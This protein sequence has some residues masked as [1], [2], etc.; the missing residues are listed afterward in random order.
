MIIQAHI[1]L[2]SCRTNDRRYFVRKG[3]LEH[4]IAKGAVRHY[5]VTGSSWAAIRRTLKIFDCY[6]YTG[7]GPTTVESWSK[8]IGSTYGRLVPVFSFPCLVCQKLQ[9]FQ[10]NRS[11]TLMNS[12]RPAP[13]DKGITV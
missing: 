6:G 3:D 8:D 9:H 5:N 4:G 13:A 12:L 1:R 11:G 7:V 10:A 2:Q